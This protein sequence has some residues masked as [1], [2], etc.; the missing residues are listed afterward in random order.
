M[1]F[2]S[3]LMKLYQS[4]IATRQ[5]ETA[6]C[7]VRYAIPRLGIIHLNTFAGV[8]TMLQW[9]VTFLTETHNEDAYRFRRF[10]AGIN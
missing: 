10:D 9:K 7:Y 3:G 6:G 2:I 1:G 8:Q 4:I 5:G